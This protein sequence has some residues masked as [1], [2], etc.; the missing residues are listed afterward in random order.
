MLCT[1]KPSLEILEARID[2]VT[3]TVKPG[4]KL[5]TLNGR[6]KTWMEMRKCEG[7]RIRPWHWMGYDGETVDG[8]TFGT[9]E[10]DGIIRLSGEVAAKRGPVALTWCDNCS[11]LD[12]C[13]TIR[14]NDLGRNW[15]EIVSMDA[16]RDARVLAG[17]TETRLIQTTPVGTTAYI[18]SRKSD[19]YM[20]CYDKTAESKG[21]YPL[22][23]WR[24]EIEYKKERANVVAR[25]LQTDAYRPSKILQLVKAAYLN[26]GHGMPCAGLPEFY[27]DRV[28][29]FETDDER[30]LAWLRSSIRPMIERMR[31]GTNT[32]VLLSAIGFADILNVDTG[33]LGL[34]EEEPESP[35]LLSGS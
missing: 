29:K 2:W 18:G 8:C 33:E 16:K 3:A 6:A 32:D 17:M 9:R 30:R 26:Y 24:Y 35:L 12:I 14:D 11:R 5:A 15:A 31:E 34:P 28:I 4:S 23:S 19:K 7:F 10:T 13:V 25:S 22:G 21:A 1:G 20:R 27:A